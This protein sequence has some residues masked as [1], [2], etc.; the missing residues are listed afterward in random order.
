MLEITLK[1]DRELIAK[2]NNIPARLHYELRRTIG[3]LMLNLRTKV[4]EEQLSGPTGAHTLNVIT[5]RLRRSVQERVEDLPEGGVAGYV[6]YGA[7]VPYARIHEMGGVIHLPDIYPTNAK[8]LAF[9]WK[10]SPFGANAPTVLRMVHAHDITMP[11]RAP[12][13]TAFGNYLGVMKREIEQAVRR[14]VTA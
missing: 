11:A 12:L 6:S 10:N 4:M 8:A 13:R 1:G 3:A 7:D 9:I 2:L 14:A 5:G